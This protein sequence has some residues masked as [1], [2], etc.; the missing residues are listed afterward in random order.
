MSARGFVRR[1]RIL[2]LVLVGTVCSPAMG[3]ARAARDA[4]LRGQVT[5]RGLGAAGM[6]VVSLEPLDSPSPV[7]VSPGPARID[8]RGLAFQP[9]VLAVPVGTTV[10][11]TNSDTV[12]HN[13]FS[14][15][16]D[17]EQAFNLGTWPRGETR[18]HRFEEAGV[19]L[20][21]CRVHPEMEAYVVVVP[22]SRFAVTDEDGSYSIPGLA[23]GEYRLRVWHER[24]QVLEMPL[25]VATPRDV[26]QDLTLEP[27][28]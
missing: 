6:A 19:T 10:E 9:H 11:F 27:L 25:T 15:T 3:A 13:I 23:A 5:I 1:R 17:G 2:L 18:S 14:P 8:Q 22:T 21:L 16:E 26:R 20:L 12:L 4:T 7:R 24:G 28:F